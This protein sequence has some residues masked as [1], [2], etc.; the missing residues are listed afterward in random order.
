MTTIDSIVDCFILFIASPDRIP[1]VHIP[2]TLV[3]P[4]S[5]HLVVKTRLIVVKT[6]LIV[7]FLVSVKVRI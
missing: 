2:Y 1:W 6:R 7:V 4:A 3:A 5:L